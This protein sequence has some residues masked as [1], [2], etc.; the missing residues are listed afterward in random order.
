MRAA[1]CSFRRTTRATSSICRTSRRCRRYCARPGMHV[2]IGSLMPEITKPTDIELPDGGKLTLEPLGRKGNRLVVG[3]FDPCVVLLNN[4]LSAGIPDIL[5]GV[6]QSVLPPLHAGWAVRRKSNHFEAYREVA[7]EFAALIGIDPW[8]I[9]PYFEQC[10]RIDFPRAQ[11]RGMPRRLRRRD[12]RRRA[13]QVPRI[14]DRRR[15]VRH[16]QS[17]RRHLR[18]GHHDGERPVGSAGTEPQAAQQDGGGEGR[19]RSARRHRAGR[20]LHVRDRRTTRS[21]SRSST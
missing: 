6:E 7:E 1:R 20:R 10:G 8:L 12:P 4:D 11:R 15:A 2:R 18:H 13:R 9:N 16:R 5:R 21:P 3:D 17:R 14:R 19:P